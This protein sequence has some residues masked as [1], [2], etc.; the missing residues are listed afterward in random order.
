[1]R[2]ETTRRSPERV[3]PAS[4]LRCNERLLEG[5]A[6]VARQHGFAD[7]DQPVAVAHGRGHVRDLVATWLA[8]LCRPAQPLE[9]LQEEGLDVVRLEPPGLGPLHLLTDAID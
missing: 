4:C 6:F 2:L 8:L 9:R 5:D 3:R 7:A 1:M